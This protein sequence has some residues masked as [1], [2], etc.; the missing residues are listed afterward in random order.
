V[1]QLSATGAVLSS[2][3]TPLAAT[4]AGTWRTV[5]QT[6][7]V[8]VGVTQLRVVLVGGALGTTRFDAVGLWG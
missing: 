7:T 3:T 4:S 6:I 1:Q 2:L 8:P 5:D